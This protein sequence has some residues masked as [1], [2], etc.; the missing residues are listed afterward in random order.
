MPICLLFSRRQDYFDAKRLLTENTG[1][2]K[3]KRKLVSFRHGH[4]WC[5][6][7]FILSSKIFLINTTV[8][9]WKLS[10][11][12]NNESYEYFWA[13]CSGPRQF[14][15]RNFGLTECCLESVSWIA[16]HF[17]S[18]NSASIKAKYCCLFCV[19]LILKT[20]FRRFIYFRIMYMR[21]NSAAQ[22][23]ATSAPMWEGWGAR[24]DK[25]QEEVQF[26]E[27]TQLFSKEPHISNIIDVNLELA[28][29]PKKYFT[30]L[31]IQCH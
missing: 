12:A 27:I 3:V 18:P 11:I 5:F 7:V 9:D 6:A 22:N 24:Y 8:P 20:L 16:F 15:K 19:F 28:D 26:K 17:V 30:S 29:P 2:I 10:Y 31:Q 4:V 21:S 23:K 14:Y 13:L 25:W 1:V